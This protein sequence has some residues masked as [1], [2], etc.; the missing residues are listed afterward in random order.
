MRIGLSIKIVPS[1][2]SFPRSAYAA[3]TTAGWLGPGLD[4]TAIISDAG[5]KDLTG[6][7]ELRVLN[8]SFTSVS[9]AG[10][11]SVA[12]HKGLQVL[13]LNG[14]SVG[15]GPS[16]GDAGMKA[17]AVLANCRHFRS[18]SRTWEMRA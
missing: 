11:K 14:T 8:L 4:N 7:P 9:D 13:F 2:P 10:I 15:D 5:V 12:T 17:L 18:S 3:V 1:V 16:A 6:L